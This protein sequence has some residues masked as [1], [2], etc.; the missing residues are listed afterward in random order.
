MS[1]LLGAIGIVFC[2]GLAMSGY[3]WPVL[4]G[5]FIGSFFG[6]AGFGGAVSGMIPGA[7]A[8]GVI[9]IALRKVPVDRSATR[10]SADEQMAHAEARRLVAEQRRAL[11]EQKVAEASFSL[12]RL[13]A[14][15]AERRWIRVRWALLATALAGL[16]I[17]F[18]TRSVDLAEE[19]K[20]LIWI[21][22]LSIAA[23]LGRAIGSWRFRMKTGVTGLDASRAAGRDELD[24]LTKTRVQ[25]FLEGVG[26]LVVMIAVV[27]MVWYAKRG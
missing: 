11:H 23:L 4:I 17:W 22:G 1:T 21:A 24:G 26:T 2:I 20:R 10:Q 3:L 8:G 15:A 25:R 13:D 27:A 5:G 6:L 19:E 16:S 7:I 14:I 18:V 9:A 12:S